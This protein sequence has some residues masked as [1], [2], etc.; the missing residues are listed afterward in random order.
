M[1]GILN[2]TPAGA[3]D[4]HAAI[5]GDEVGLR[6]LRDAVDVALTHGVSEITILGETGLPVVLRVEMVGASRL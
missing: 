2:L 1:V 4:S 6:S 5:V 3:V